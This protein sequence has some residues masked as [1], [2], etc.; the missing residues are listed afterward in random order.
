MSVN[1]TPP[2]GSSA[3]TAVAPLVPE[4]PWVR[5]RRKSGKEV[6][7]TRE[8]SGS[9]SAFRPAPKRQADPRDSGVEFT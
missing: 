6:I 1:E 7:K 5:Q 8:K 3:P 4:L 9:E 2:T